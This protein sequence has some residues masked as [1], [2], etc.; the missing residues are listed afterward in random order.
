MSLRN[1]MA[2][3]KGDMSIEETHAGPRKCSLNPKLLRE[4]VELQHGTTVREL[5]ARTEVHYSMSRLFF[6]PIGKAK[7]LSQLIPHELTE[8]LRKKRVAARLD[9]LFHQVERPSLERTLTR[10]EKWCLYDNRKHE[11]VR[12]D[13]HTPPK[14]FPKPNLHPTNVLLSVWWCTSAAIH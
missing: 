13:K 6:V 9:F 4:T 12:S 3:S 7:N 11:T 14:S 2:S 1:D 5:A 10:D 8:I